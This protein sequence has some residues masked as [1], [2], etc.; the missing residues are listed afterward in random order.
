MVD[1]TTINIGLMKVGDEIAVSVLPTGKGVESIPSL[2]LTG[3]PDELDEGFFAQ[4]QQP[5]KRSIGLISEISEI[6]KFLEIKKKAKEESLQSKK[7]KPVNTQPEKKTPPSPQVSLFSPAPNPVPSVVESTL[8]EDE[9]D[10]LYS[11][12]EDDFEKLLIPE[13]N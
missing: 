13:K 2:V 9:V 12:D 10:N 5:L 8:E 7:A 6:E 3:R 11:E 4:I 1:G